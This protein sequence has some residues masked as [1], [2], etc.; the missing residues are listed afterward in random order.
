MANINRGIPMIW[1]SGDKHLFH[2]F[3]LWGKKNCVQCGKPLRR[4]DVHADG[5]SLCCAAEVKQAERPP[6]PGF[7][8]VWEMN[9]TI[10]DNHNSVVEKGDLVYEIGDFALKCNAKEARDAR[11]EMKGNFYLIEG[12]H[13]QVATK[14]PDCWVWIKDRIRIKPAGWDTPHITLDHYAG[15]VWHGSHKGTWQLYGHSHGHLP[16]EPQWLSFDV[17]VDAQDFFP[18]NIE[19]VIEKMKTKIPLWEA[20]KKRLNKPG[21]VGN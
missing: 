21:G 3:M 6:R 18:I 19:Q 11:Y 9:K 17:G 5:Q 16:E 2:D 13:D 1:F 7:K 12:N 15:R 8:D 20:W 4:Q 10:I 14:I